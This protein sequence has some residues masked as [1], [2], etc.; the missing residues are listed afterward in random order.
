MNTVYCTTIGAD[1]SDRTTKICVMSKESGKPKIVRETSIPTT[2][3]GFRA[4]LE[5]QDKSAPLVFE[6]GTHC[7]WI[8]KV[9]TGMGFKTIVANPAR[10]RMITESNTKND[11]NDA[12]TLARMALADVELL[13]PVRLRDDEHQK[14]V[15]LHEIRDQ[16]PT[17]P[18][19]FSK[20][21]V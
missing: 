12:R 14:M 21:A 9:G 16:L 5:G 10:L 11:K 1:V 6:T 19:H 17:L 13:H 20:S 3:D 4:F 2:P 15:N 8:D 18:L 7:R